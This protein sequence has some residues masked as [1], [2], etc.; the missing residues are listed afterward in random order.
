MIFPARCL[1][2]GLVATASVAVAAPPVFSF[3]D[4]KGVSA[5]SFSVDAPLN[6]ITGFATGFRGDVTFDPEKPESISGTIEAPLAG[7]ALPNAQMRDVL[8]TR[9][10][11][12]V[13]EYPVLKLEI[14]QARGP[15]LVETGVW[16]VTLVAELSCRGKMTPVEMPARIRYLKGQARDRGGARQGDLLFL[17]S[18]FVLKRSD[19]GIKTSGGLDKVGNDIRIGGELVGYAP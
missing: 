5:V 13:D 16:D 14:K 10:W 8:M 11:M 7:V 15:K 6:A 19:F 18:D 3:M 17:R 1:I 12:N 9:D 2:S 4:P